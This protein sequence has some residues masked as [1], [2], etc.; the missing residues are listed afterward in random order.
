MKKQ[1]FLLASAILIYAPSQ[2]KSLGLDNLVKRCLPA[3]KG[4]LAAQAQ[5]LDA[6]LDI[7][8]LHVT[9][10]DNRLGNPYK[11]VW[12][13]CEAVK[14]SGE[15]VILKTMTQKPPFAKCF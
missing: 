2:A 7:E 4:K 5:T 13:A 14:P 11:Y 10:I 8:T 3:A 12:F 9:G 15:R 6:Q 1:I